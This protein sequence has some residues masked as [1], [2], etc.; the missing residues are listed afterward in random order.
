[1]MYID[2]LPL[3]LSVDFWVRLLEISNQRQSTSV[4]EEEL[5]LSYSWLD[6]NPNF[7][8]YARVPHCKYKTKRYAE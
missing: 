3:S 8:Y 4:K 5:I 2:P 6:Y 7:C 1:M